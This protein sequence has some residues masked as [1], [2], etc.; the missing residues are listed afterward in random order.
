MRRHV[1]VKRKANPHAVYYFVRKRLK[2]EGFDVES[3]DIRDGF[4]ELHARKSDKTRILL[5][6]VRDASLVISGRKGRFEVRLHVGIWGRDIAFPIVEA[7]ATLGIAS[8]FDMHSVHQFEQKLWEEIVH[9]IDASLKVCRFCGLVFKSESEL[10]KHLKVHELQQ[11]IVSGMLMSP[12][13][14]PGIAIKEMT[15]NPYHP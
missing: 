14:L 5:E 4:L 11:P 10:E 12:I 6:K 1:F 9:K 7:V 15:I 13:M 2:S 3:E 8:A